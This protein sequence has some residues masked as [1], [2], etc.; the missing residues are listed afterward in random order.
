MLILRSSA[1]ICSSA[2]EFSSLEEPNGAHQI[3]V[4]AHPWTR[5]ISRMGARHPSEVLRNFLRFA[6]I[7]EMLLE[8]G[9]AATTRRSSCAEHAAAAPE[10]FKENEVR[11]GRGHVVK[12]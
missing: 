7:R 9:A 8:Q 1:A 6:R 3:P 10:H 12:K 5:K 4:P 2:F 11:D